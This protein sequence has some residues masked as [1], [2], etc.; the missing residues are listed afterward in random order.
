MRQKHP[1]YHEETR[2]RRPNCVNF[3]TSDLAAVPL[4]TDTHN[5][6]RSYVRICLTGVAIGAVRLGLYVEEWQAQT[7][8]DWLPSRAISNEDR[9]T[10]FQ[11]HCTGRVGMPRISKGCVPYSYMPRSESRFSPISIGLLPYPKATTGV[12]SPF[13]L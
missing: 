9:S 1:L 12:V 2:R 6:S 3:E 7:F 5:S 11:L 4:E 13:H 10:E 8:P